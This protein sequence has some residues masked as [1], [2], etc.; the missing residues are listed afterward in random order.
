M[1]GRLDDRVA[2]I[3]GGASGLGRATAGLFARE[4]ADIVI[5]DV[6]PQRGA[7][8]VAEVE[9][10]GRRALFVEADITSETDNEALADTAVAEFGGIDVLVAAAG[11]PYSGYVTGQDSK[12]KNP[13]FDPASH[14]LLKKSLEQWEKVLEV[15]L[16]GTFLTNRA[17]AQ[18]M[19]A[20]GRGGS[21]VNI[22]S[23]TAKLPVPGY[24]DYCVS[25]AGVWM[26]SQVL[27]L[28]L[29]P[30]GIR[31]N[32]VAP[33]FIRTP[34]SDVEAADEDRAQAA[35]DRVPLGRMGQP[36]DVAYTA[37][38]LACDESSF[39]TGKLLHPDGGLFTG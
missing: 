14:S 31:V 10:T 8:V 29:G 30:H 34:M 5:A 9:A 3:T 4:G 11:I 37:L 28:E 38:F 12:A 16:T 23:G 17:V 36:P 18:R 27:A 7:E 21:I 25:K 1:S 33:G 24:G 22:S 15:N 2:V 35:I 19:V 20:A 6:H 39:M 32:S 13:L 26:L